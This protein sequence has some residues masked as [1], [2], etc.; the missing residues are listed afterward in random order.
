MYSSYQ[1]VFTFF[2]IIILRRWVDTRGYDGYSDYMAR[3]K[4]FPLASAAYSSSP[5]HCIDNNYGNASLATYYSGE[6]DPDRYDSCA[7]FTAVLHDDEAIVLSFRGTVRFMQLVEET[8]WSA[9]HRKTKWVA[10]GYVSTYFYNAFMA[11][12]NGGLNE[13]FEALVAT[14]PNYNIWVTGHSLGASMASLA[15]SYVIARKSISG[16][17]V[18]L[19][20]YGQPRTGDAAFAA[21]HNRLVCQ[22]NSQAFIPETH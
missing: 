5:Q 9:F 16:G 4:F 3:L 6:C 19:I 15:A 22:N 13:S 21:S 10:G 20:T 2:F 17:N 11:V 8:N 1:C 18:K 12:W 7:G 14:Y